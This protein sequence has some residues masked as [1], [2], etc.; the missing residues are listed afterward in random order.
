MFAKIFVRHYL[1]DLLKVSQV[2]Q[3]KLFFQ[4]QFMVPN[5][6]LLLKNCISNKAR[7]NYSPILA[8]CLLL[9]ENLYC[10]CRRDDILSLCM[11]FFGKDIWL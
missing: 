8:L 1:P 3:K 4:V 6:I 5:V 9:K 11:V 7:S 2:V 10:L